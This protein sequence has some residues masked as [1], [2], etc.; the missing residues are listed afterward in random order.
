MVASYTDVLWLVTSR[1]ALLSTWGGGGVREVTL[2]VLNEKIWVTC[3]VAS[4]TAGFMP[5]PSFKQLILR[6]CCSLLTFAMTEF[7]CWTWSVTHLSLDRIILDSLPALA[8]SSSISFLFSSSTS[9]ICCSNS[10]PSC[11]ISDLYLMICFGG[12]WTIYQP[13]SCS[14]CNQTPSEPHQSSFCWFSTVTLK[15]IFLGV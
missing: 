9:F 11:S 7:I 4:R 2:E 1:H 5:V 15:T 14:N 10:C 3:L 13:V 8:L 12:E 6:S